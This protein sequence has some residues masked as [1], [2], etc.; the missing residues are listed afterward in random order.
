MRRRRLSLKRENRPA[1]MEIFPLRLI[2]FIL[3]AGLVLTAC[4]KN[5]FLSTPEMIG[6]FERVNLVAG[7]EA[8][9]SINRLHGLDVAPTMN[10]IAEYGPKDTRDLLYISYY[11]DREDAENEFARMIKKIIH[12]KKGPFFHF[13]PIPPAED[14][15]FFLIGMGAEHYVYLSDHCIVWFQTYQAF[16][17]NVPESLRRLYPV[18]K[19][20]PAVNI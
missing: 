20:H 3:A 11:E 4:E 12:S 17:L 18:G 1:E 2:W 5:E 19:L 9:E 8:L 14:R 15:T 13:M 7:T 10:I 6:E 16:D